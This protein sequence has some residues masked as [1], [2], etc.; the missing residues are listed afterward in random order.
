MSFDQL[1][2]H[3]MAPSICG[4]KPANLFS[5][6]EAMFCRKAFFQWKKHLGSHGLSCISER[7]RG[8]RILI[9]VYNKDWIETL[10]LQ[11]DVNSY[12]EKK[13]YFSNE[14]G[15]ITAE[16]SAN[17]FIQLK[18][19]LRCTVKSGECFPHE[20]GIILGYPLQDVID[21][22]SNCGKNC[23]YCGTWK[24]Y[25]DVY[26]ARQVQALFRECSSLCSKW[27]DQGYS[28][29]KIVKTYKKV[30]QAA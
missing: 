11:K 10:L 25:S 23:K 21:F 19:R 12:L 28:L 30:V 1:M 22:E 26:K 18:E 3:Y 8:G 13:G 4:I 24:C 9:L 7:I 29:G 15:S 20:V 27:F 16:V 2:I 5:V 6:S 17:F 14:K